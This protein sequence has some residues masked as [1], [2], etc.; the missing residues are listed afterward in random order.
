MPTINELIDLYREVEDRII[1]QQGEVDDIIEEELVSLHGSIADKL[2]ACQGYIKYAEGQADWLKAEASDLVARAK[3]MENSVES[4]RKRMV[5]LMQTTGNDKIKGK[6]SYS[7]RNTESW[8][9]NHAA[10]DE[11]LEMLCDEGL[12]VKE[13]KIKPDISAIK[14]AFVS[15]APPFIDVTKNVSINIR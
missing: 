11:V 4:L 1:E 10:T 8:K 12:A 7:L 13:T 6:H 5:F 15:G 2:D 9:M 14:K 3:T